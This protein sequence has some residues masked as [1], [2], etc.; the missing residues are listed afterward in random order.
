M[1]SAPSKPPDPKL[2][3]LQQ[4]EKLSKI[5]KEDRDDCLSCRL[6]GASAFIGLGAYVYYSGQQGLK[7][8][9]HMIA[10]QSGMGG[11][12]WRLRGIALLSSSFIGMGLYRLV[13]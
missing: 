12:K 8:R 3:A 4:P 13:N 6:I 9:G 5:L 1:S 7:E 2:Y 11:V 10:R